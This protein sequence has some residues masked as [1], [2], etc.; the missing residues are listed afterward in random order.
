MVLRKRK[1]GNTGAKG[2]LIRHRWLELILRRRKTWEIRSKP[3][4]IRGRIEL[5][6]AG[7]STMVGSAEI[8]GCRRVTKLELAK[9]ITKHRVPNS[10][11]VIPYKYAYAWILKNAKRY[12]KP[13]PYRHPYG[14]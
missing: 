14:A 6:E 3:T 13:K 11:R 8:V 12:P 1:R 5:G 9:S 7:T 10:A 4:Q 2:L